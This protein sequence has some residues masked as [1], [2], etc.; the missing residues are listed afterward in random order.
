MSIHGLFLSI[1]VNEIII[2]E[3]EMER[4]TLSLTSKIIILLH[5]VLQLT[6][7][8]CICNIQLVIMVIMLTMQKQLN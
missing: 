5:T 6:F 2:T 4:I 8:K 7:D 1:T 3:A